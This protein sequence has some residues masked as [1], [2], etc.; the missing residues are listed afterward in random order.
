MGLVLSPLTFNC[1]CTDNV[2]ENSFTQNPLLSD[3]LINELNKFKAS[4]QFKKMRVG[5][6]INYMFHIFHETSPNLYRF[7][8]TKKSDTSMDSTQMTVHQKGVVKGSLVIF[9][10]SPNDR[11]IKFYTKFIP[12]NTEYKALKVGEKLT[13][14]INLGEKS[15]LGEIIRTPDGEQP[16]IIV[17]WK[18]IIG[19]ATENTQISY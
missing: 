17:Y 3:T 11:H 14:D 12:N 16:N 13:F 2:H 7:K 18:I 6:T 15:L 4:E 5:E 19:R 1:Y 9:S 10:D 8:I